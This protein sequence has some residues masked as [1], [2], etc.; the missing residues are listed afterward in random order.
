MKEY[1]RKTHN[2]PEQLNQEHHP[3]KKES[4][5][6]P[7]NLHAWEQGGTP[8]TETPFEPMSDSHEA[9][10]AQAQSN[11]RRAN[12]VLHLQQTY[13]NAYVQRLF[14]S[15][16]A[17]AKMTVNPP[18]DVYEQEAD[19]VADMVTG[20]ISAQIHRQ[21][22]EEEE[23]LQMQP[24]EEEE[25]QARLREATAAGKEV[26]SSKKEIKLVNEAAQMR[27]SE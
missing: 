22:E 4:Q 27:I 5:P 2:K 1:K 8:I 6:L 9:L 19:R 14:S 18:G 25:V 16:A 7:G 12:L 3:S 23:E 20:A 26:D 17:Q 13:G 10:L 24:E 15:M 11:E 21:P